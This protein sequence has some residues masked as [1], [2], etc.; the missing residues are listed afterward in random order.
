MLSSIR[1]WS[2]CFQAL[3]CWCRSEWFVLLLILA[4]FDKDMCT[5]GEGRNLIS[6][7]GDFFAYF[8]EVAASDG[9]SRAPML[10][11]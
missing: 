9:E 5:K 3:F 7:V 4:P 11:A 8:R 6:T 1:Q 2:P 10:P